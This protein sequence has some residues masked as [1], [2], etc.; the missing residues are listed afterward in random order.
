M[1]ATTTVKINSSD[2]HLCVYI[3]ILML[4]YPNCMTII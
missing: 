2:Q 1:V 4:R 3:Y